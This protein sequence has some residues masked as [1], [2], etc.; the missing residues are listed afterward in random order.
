MAYGGDGPFVDDDTFPTRRASLQ[1]ALD[2]DSTD[3]HDK[4]KN[5]ESRLAAVFVLSTAAIKERRASQSNGSKTVSIEI[6]NAASNDGEYITVA[7][8]GG[9]TQAEG[10]EESNEDFEETAFGF[11]NN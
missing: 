11:G 8:A 1:Q 2:K 4:S 5:I 3:H 9:R 10:K 7:E 6:D